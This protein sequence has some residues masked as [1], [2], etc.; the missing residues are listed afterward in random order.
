MSLSQ[1]DCVPCQGGISALNEAE[2]KEFLKNLPL[3]ELKENATKL[4][5]EFNF[6]N[7]V[8]SLEFTNKVGEVAEKE[9]H[10]PD[11]QLGW[12]Y[13]KIYIQTHKING[14]HENDFI[15]ASK[16]DKLV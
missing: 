14:L 3:W 11:I 8:K 10:H 9:K 2:A 6:K 16:I 5:R 4:Y 12:G 1:K 15:L 13:V 7:F